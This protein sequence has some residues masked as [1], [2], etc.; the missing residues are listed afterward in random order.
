MIL[1]ELLQRVQSLYS[2]GVQSDDSRLTSRHIYSKLVTVRSTL[3]S[4]KAKHKQKIN[5]WNYQTLSCIEMIDVRPH[6]C[7]CAP[8]P[9]CDTVKRS[10]YKIPKIISDYNGN[11][12]DYVMSIDGSK[13]FDFTNRSELLSIRGNRYTA[14]SSR[15]ILDK[16]YIYLYGRNTPKVIQMRAL[17]DDPI[18]AMEFI[19]FCPEDNIECIDI[20][21]MEFPFDSSSID[22]YVQL[23]AQELS[24]FFGQRPQ[25]VSNNN[26]DEQQQQQ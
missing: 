3:I 18:E 24:T 13:K 19:S 17:F 4:Q 10:K 7:P 6:E 21:E 14:H 20:F 11:L 26:Q 23:T 15:Y 12:I 22:T 9:G 16:D 2:K 5:D 1:G 8:Y 25:D